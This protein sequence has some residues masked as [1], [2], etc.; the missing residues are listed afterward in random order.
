MDTTTTRR[1]LLTAAAVMPALI[2]APAF[3]TTSPIDDA[4]WKRA[5]AAA[6]LAEEQ[7]D[8]AYAVDC[9]AEEAVMDAAELIK[10]VAIVERRFAPTYSQLNTMP[11]D[12]V[13]RLY[14]PPHVDGPHG[15]GIVVAEQV[16]LYRERV[17]ALKV[18]HRVAERKEHSSQQA[19]VWN[20]AMS[21]AFATPAPS[22]PALADKIALLL[23]YDPNEDIIN[24]VLADARRLAK[25]EG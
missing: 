9:D 4:A 13:A 7:L 11:L 3:A 8:A 10:P 19:K 20:A 6:Q 24:S 2:V 15:G 18:E 1:A 12:E 14:E 23:R 5:H 16:R 25:M 21:D 22:V 17:E